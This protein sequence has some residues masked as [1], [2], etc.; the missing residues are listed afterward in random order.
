M[1]ITVFLSRS[2]GLLNWGPG[3]PGSLGHG[4]HSSIFS[5]TNLN[6]LSLGLYNNLTPTL[7]PASITILHSIQP[8]NS[9]GRSPLISWYLQPDAP[10]I[11]TGA[12]L[13]LTD[14]PGQRSIMQH[15]EWSNAQYVNTSP[16]TIQ[17][18]TACKPS[19]AWTFSVMWVLLL[20]LANSKISQNSWLIQVT[21]K[22]RI[23]IWVYQCTIIK[24]II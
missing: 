20:K 13:L 12:F 22:T 4:P 7:L 10:V 1:A 14:W 15:M 23:L 8:L 2:P 6:F 11:Y 24:E 21:T 17:P 3:G 16:N 5:P 18:N 19:M 9:Q